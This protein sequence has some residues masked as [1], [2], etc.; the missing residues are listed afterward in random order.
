MKRWVILVIGLLLASLT[1]SAQLSEQQQIQKL[2]LVY[3]QIRSNY[4]DNV[5][6]EPLVQ[7][8]VI[9]T[10]RQLDPHSS[11]LDHEQMAALR[12]RLRGE[13]AGVGIRYIV[14][15]DTLVVRGIVAKSPAERANIEINDRIVAID[16]RPIVGISTDSVSQLLRGNAGSNVCLTIKRRSTNNP[17]N[18]KLKRANIESSAITASFRIDDVGYIAISKFSKP[19]ASEFLTALKSLREISSLVVDLRD[20]SG[21]AITSAIDLTGL[22]LRKG[23]I[24]VSTEGRTNNIV[25]DTKRD[26]A[27]IDLPLVV[28]INENSASA[29]EIFAGAIQDHDRGVVIGHT[30]YGKGLVQRVIDFKDGTGMCLT[31]ARY[32]TPSGRIIQ[33]PYVMGHGE[34]YMSDTLRYMHPDSVSHNH[35]LLFKTLHRGRTVYG[36]GGITPDIYIDTDSLKLSPSLTSLYREGLFEHLSVD[37]W[38][39]IS[40]DSLLGDYPTVEAF[41]SC[42]N[43]ENSIVERLYQQAALKADSLTSLDHSFIRAMILSTMAERLYGTDARY[44]IYNS[45]FDP[46]ARQALAIANDRQRIEAILSGAEAE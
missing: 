36:G 30:S 46:M 3:Q 5:P 15:R 12:T 39:S 25:Y 29:S 23:D 7:E 33:R 26:G 42:Y 40:A 44:L 11:Y 6:L 9:A 45:S 10:L 41:N 20:N 18:V 22:F 27:L 37:I 31:V 4:V 32:K 1:A 13:F 35:E 17:L 43:V 19:L 2:N 34:E 8:A 28:I 16:G 14:H 21:G 24:I 38:D